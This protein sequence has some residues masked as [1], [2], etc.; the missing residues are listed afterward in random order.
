[1]NNIKTMKGYGDEVSVVALCLLCGIVGYLY[2]I[3]LPD[4]IQQ[5]QNQEIIKIL[6]QIRDKDNNEKM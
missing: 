6:T 4:K 3:S 5:Q 1:M 2:V